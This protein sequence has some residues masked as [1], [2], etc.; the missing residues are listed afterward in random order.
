MRSSRYRGG[1][2][3]SKGERRLISTRLPVSQAD[4]IY[5]RADALEITVTDYVAQ[6][7]LEHLATTDFPG[8]RPQG[9]LIPMAEAMPHSRG[10]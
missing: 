8:V 2:R 4:E 7:L 6:V 3:P 10:A 1:G 9:E 5:E